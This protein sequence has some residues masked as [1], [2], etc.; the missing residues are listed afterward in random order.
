MPCQL[1]TRNDSLANKMNF[2]RR[3][4]RHRWNCACSVRILHPCQI[5]NLMSRHLNL[6]GRP[7]YLPSGRRRGRG[8]GGGMFHFRIAAIRYGIQSGS[9]STTNST[10]H[11]PRLVSIRYVVHANKNIGDLC[12]DVH[13]SGGRGTVSEATDAQMSGG[14]EKGPA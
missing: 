2:A 5:R 8:R 7:I 3:R 1:N 4:R 12:D 9:A 14:G 11:W 6:D 10:N 13:S